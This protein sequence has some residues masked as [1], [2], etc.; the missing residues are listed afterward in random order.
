M[1]VCEDAWSHH[2][3]RLLL[4][5]HRRQADPR[6][7]KLW[8]VLGD[9]QGSDRHYEKAWEVSGRRSARSQRSLGRSALGRKDF[10]AAAAA[11]ERALALSPLFPDAWFSLGYCWLRL[12]QN[13]KALQ[14][15]ARLCTAG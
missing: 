10:G 9:I 8:C 7:A 6:D 3:P 13:T 4:L 5:D 1:G 11:Y 14:V 12:D 2:T 15:R